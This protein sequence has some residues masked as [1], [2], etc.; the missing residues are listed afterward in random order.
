MNQI[1][2][3]YVRFSIL[4]YIKIFIQLQVDKNTILSDKDNTVKLLNDNLNM[5]FLNYLNCNNISTKSAIYNEIMRWISDGVDS[6]K[7]STLKH[8]SKDSKI[9][10]TT[11]TYIEF[12]IN[13][14]YWNEDDFILKFLKID[15]M[16]LDEV[17]NID[18][19]LKR[20]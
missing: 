16:S 18:N 12:L 13:H 10:F 17:L 19:P 8:F 11:S 14:L 9:D 2:N 4:E 5:S 20:K 3:D 7:I 15:S 6:L 1:I